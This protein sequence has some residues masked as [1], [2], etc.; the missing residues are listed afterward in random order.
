MKFVEKLIKLESLINAKNDLE[1]LIKMN[2]VKKNNLLFTKD[3]D[4]EIIKDID[5]TIATVDEQLIEVKLCIQNANTNE[6]HEDGNSNNYYIYKLSSLNRRLANLREL[7]QKGEYNITA[8]AKDPPRGTTYP[9][10]KKI[11]DRLTTKKEIEKRNKEIA[12]EIID[13][14]KSITEIKAKLSEFNKRVEVKVKVFDGFEGHK[15]LK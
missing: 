9:H 3:Y 5:E 13:V 7:E 10:N 6:V 8:F 14:E 2:S 12:N 15:S 4:A 11:R 1:M